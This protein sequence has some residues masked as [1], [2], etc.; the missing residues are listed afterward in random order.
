MRVT[1]SEDLRSVCIIP[2]AAILGAAGDKD[3]KAVEWDV[4]RYSGG[5]DMSGYHL[6]VH[7]TNAEGTGSCSE[8]L[9]VEVGEDRITFIWLVPRLAMLSEGNVS[10]GFKAREV[11]GNRLAHEFNSAPG[12]FR[13]KPAE[14]NSPQGDYLVDESDNIIVFPEVKE[15]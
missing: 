14:S 9:D 7:Y 3:V 1:V 4:P 6:Q 8:A 2:R 15:D 13:V 12:A 11:T 5:Q 10:A